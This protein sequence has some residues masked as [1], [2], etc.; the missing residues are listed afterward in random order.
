MAKT[1]ETKL[2]TPWLL[3]GSL[4]T[5]ALVSGFAWELGSNFAYEAINYFDPPPDYAAI[6]ESI[7]NLKKK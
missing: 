2:P 5:A 4:F 3:V 7:Y 6:C 1:P